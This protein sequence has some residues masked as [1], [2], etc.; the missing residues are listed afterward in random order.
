MTPARVVALFAVACLASGCSLTRAPGQPA[1]PG[2]PPSGVDQ[3]VRVPAPTAGDRLLELAEQFVGAPYRY[4]GST[5]E[6]FDCSGL[7]VRSHELAGIAV[8]RTV[9]EQH[10]AAQAV[11]E[12]ALQPGDLVFF[13]SRRGR[14]DHVG[15]YAGEGRFVHAPRT[16]RPVGYDRL[17]DHWFQTRFVGAGRFWTAPPP[18]DIRAPAP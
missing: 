12:S 16:G 17:D 8:P 7:V 13:A 4:G 1:P 9:L 11:P 14:V 6:G 3:P 10:A 2:A 15:I 5:P 18:S